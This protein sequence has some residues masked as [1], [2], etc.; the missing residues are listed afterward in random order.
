MF[1]VCVCVCCWNICFLFHAIILNIFQD[2]ELAVFKP[3]FIKMFKVFFEMPILKVFW[4]WLRSKC[5]KS[6]D[7]IAIAICDS[8][9]ES[10]I[11]SDLRQCEPS[12]KNSLSD[13]V[14]KEIGIAILTAI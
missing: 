8:N 11:T 12:Q 3:F 5:S 14:V 2:F 10:Q 1:G 7:L 9:R 4:V 6:R 13:F